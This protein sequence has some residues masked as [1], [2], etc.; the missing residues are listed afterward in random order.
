MFIDTNVYERLDGRPAAAA[1]AA[2]GAPA[3]AADGNPDY[4]PE[5]RNRYR[6][7][8]PDEQLNDA[9]KTL[10]LDVLHPAYTEENNEFQRGLRTKLAA[11]QAKPENAQGLVQYF[12]LYQLKSPG[13]EL[14]K[15]YRFIQRRRLVRAIKR[16]DVNAITRMSRTD[17]GI[18]SEFIDD[19][20][21][22][23][24]PFASF[25]TTT[26]DRSGRTALPS[27][28]AVFNE[29]DIA[30]IKRGVDST[31][32]L[33]QKGTAEYLNQ[34]YNFYTG[35]SPDSPVKKEIR[36][37]MYFYK[38]DDIVVE[39]FVLAFE[40][41]DPDGRAVIM[42]GTPLS[43]DLNPG[44]ERVYRTLPN[45][46]LMDIRDAVLDETY[47]LPDSL[48]AILGMITTRA[49]EA[50]EPTDFTYSS[51]NMDATVRTDPEIPAGPQINP[52]PSRP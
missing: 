12:G 19:E 27:K 46:I 43:R 33:V 21:A 49:T 45:N 36:D 4:L 2:A 23:R 6:G 15:L 7:V 5:V 8:I 35:F 39:E 51:R 29:K 13:E 31:N 47:R 11:E 3:G 37:A 20:Y 1:G 52:P 34:F 9:D 44:G 22:A 42:A 17:F 25:H 32:F 14:D 40:G 10:I 30:V 48:R 50:G 26:Q 38:Q 41:E 28:Y 24:V 16:G 18:L